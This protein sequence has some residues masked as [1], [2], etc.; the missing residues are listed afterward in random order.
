MGANEEII[1]AYKAGK[2]QKAL[3]KLYVSNK[4]LW[5][6]VC[7]KYAGIMEMDDLMQE[8]Y[9]SMV[10]ALNC[11]DETQGILWT[12]YA[13]AHLDGHLKRVVDNNG[14]IRISVYML[15]RVKQ[16][17]RLENEYLA[18]MGR[19]PTSKETR[20]RLDITEQQRIELMAVL[21]LS[22]LGSIDTPTGEDGAGTIADLIKDTAASDPE[23]LAIQ[24]E[25]KAIIW[26]C[27]ERLE[28][29]QNEIIKKVY[30][31]EKSIKAAG[32]EL[33]VN[34]ALKHKAALDNLK[35]MKDMQHIADVKSRRRINTRRLGRELYLTGSQWM[36][37]PER[38]V[39]KYNN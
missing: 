17:K 34:G 22:E 6:K 35:R 31:E 39:I 4:G 14:V 10:N 33:E 11:Y 37:T 20:N 26:E 24:E 8:A 25:E 1:E 16:Y 29:V 32:Q 38:L 30:Q 27:V 18:K 2:N 36:S 23:A 19:K 15:E 28:P 13:A 7:R 12:T 3:E 21:E 9:I 5:Q